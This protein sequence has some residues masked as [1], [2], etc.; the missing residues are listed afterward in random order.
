MTVSRPAG[1]ACGNPQARLSRLNHAKGR[2]MIRTLKQGATEAEKT[3]AARKIRQ[4]VEAILEDI[5][6]RGDA[7]VRDLSAKFDKWEPAAFRLRPDEIQSLID[8]LPGQVITDIKF[9]QTQIRRFAHAQKDALRDI[10]VETLPGIRS[11]TR[12]SRSTALAATCP[13]A[14]TRWSP[15]PTCRC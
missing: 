4:T 8:S 7:A 10:E 11:A 14:A 3:E 15:P 6:A 9:A 2:Q 12:T 13:A 1:A 5:S